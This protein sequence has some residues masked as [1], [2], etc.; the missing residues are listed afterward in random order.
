M[1]WRKYFGMLSC[2]VRLSKCQ[3]PGHIWR[4][5]L[6]LSPPNSMT[7]ASTSTGAGVRRSTFN[8]CVRCTVTPGAHRSPKAR[9][10]TRSAASRLTAWK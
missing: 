8:S 3:S 4:I 7:H 2:R 10:A 9:R 5:R 1:G 6:E